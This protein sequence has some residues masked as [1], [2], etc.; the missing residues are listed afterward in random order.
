MACDRIVQL[1]CEPDVRSLLYSVMSPW[2]R[3]ANSSLRMTLLLK[4]NM[5]LGSAASSGVANIGQQADIL[6][7][8][9]VLEKGERAFER[10]SF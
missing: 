2:V 3:A 6:A 10:H 4:L 9:V 7:D 1:S 8:A 5:K